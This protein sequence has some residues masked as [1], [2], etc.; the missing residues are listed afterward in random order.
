MRSQFAAALFIAL[1]MT[2]GT[3]RAGEYAFFRRLGFTAGSAWSE[4][5]AIS[6]DGTTIVGISRAATSQAIEAFV[7]TED[8]GIEG[9]GALPVPDPV[10]TGISVSADGTVV[11][12]GSRGV[13]GWESFR[14]T[15][16]DGMVSI[17]DLPGGANT[18]EGMGVSADG[19]VIVGYAGSI[20]NEGRQNS[21]YEAYRWTSETG[22]TPLGS[23]PGQAFHSAAKAVSADGSVIVGET[24][25]NP[26]GSNRQAFRWTSADGMMPLTGAPT[27][28]RSEA[29]AVSADGTVIVGTANQT[30]FRWTASGGM[31][32]LP[33]P[34]GFLFSS[35]TDVSG[36]GRVVVFNAWLNQQHA[37]FIWEEGRGVTSLSARLAELN[38][39][40]WQMLWVQGISD[41]GLKLTGYGTNPSGRTESWVASIAIVPEPSAIS[42]AVAAAAFLFAHRILIRENDR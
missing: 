41:D 33:I 37:A 40:S 14:W 38:V 18:S 31:Q 4:A 13:K 17:G 39:V 19:S 3:A 26:S 6:A 35:A 36:D 30:A 1:V 34:A 42:I 24:I 29:L 15:R 28:A 21:H 9:I 10:S 32:L 22:L 2:A 11:V 12:G 25:G 7:W 16:T 23:L 27:N 5:R 20:N 8:G